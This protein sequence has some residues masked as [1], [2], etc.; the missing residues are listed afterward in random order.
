[1][2]PWAV[3]A[4]EVDLETAGVKCWVNGDLRQDSAFSQLIFDI[5]TLIE[6]LSEGITLNPGDIIATGTPAG[7]GIGHNPPVYLSP[8]DEVRISIDGIGTLENRFA[9]RA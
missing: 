7:V 4:D 5:P 2:G 1:M 9:A 3:T 8:G 6:T